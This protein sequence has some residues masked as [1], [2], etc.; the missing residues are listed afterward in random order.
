[1]YMCYLASPAAFDALDAAAVNGHLDVG[2]YIVPHVKDKKY[3][4]GT[5]AAG[6]LAHAIS[7]RHMDVVE[8]LFGQDSSWWDLAEAF[9]AA[10]AVEQHTLA[11]RIFEA[12]RREDKEAFLVE[13]AGHEANYSH[14]AT[15]E[16]LYDTK[17][18]S[19]G[20]F[21]EAM[22]DVATWRRP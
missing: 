13:V 21:D 3:V 11:D 15:M 18:V 8:Y 5:K 2:R 4:H 22:M 14:I 19:R 1:M 7:A 9:I 17:R 10:V 20:T 6:I 12:Y 16:F